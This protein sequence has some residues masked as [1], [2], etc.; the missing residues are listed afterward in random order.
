M[1]KHS[2]FQY[3]FHCLVSSLLFV[4]TETEQMREYRDCSVW[5]ITHTTPLLN[6]WNALYLRESRCDAKSYSEKTHHRLSSPALNSSVW[7]ISRWHLCVAQTSMWLRISGCF[8]TWVHPLCIWGYVPRDIMISEESRQKQWGKTT[9]ASKI[10]D[11]K[12]LSDLKIFPHVASKKVAQIIRTFLNFIF[13]GK[14]L[15]VYE[16]LIKLNEHTPW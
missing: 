2:L 13:K 10:D 15:N 11:H 16:C 5:K 9:R 7:L 4:C 1:N 6:L 12:K 3:S 14:P 8:Y